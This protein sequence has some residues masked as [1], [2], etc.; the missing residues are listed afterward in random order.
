MSCRVVMQVR[1]STYTLAYYFKIGVLILNFTACGFLE[2]KTKGNEAMAATVQDTTAQNAPKDDYIV[3]PHV[4]HPQFKALSAAFETQ[5]HRFEI[6]R[7]AF[8]YNGTSFFIGDTEEKI[9][10]IFGEPNS[11]INTLKGE[12]YVF[13]YKKLKVEIWFNNNNNT[14]KS[15]GLLMSNYEGHENTP[16]KVVTFRKTPYHLD[17]TLNEFL[18]LSDLNHE[19]NLGHTLHSFYIKN[20]KKCS[21]I[22][23]KTSIGSTPSY[24]TI[25]GG[26]ITMKGDF[27]TKYSKPIRN[28]GMSLIKNN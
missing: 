18:E 13:E 10:E 21:S 9:I 25:G 12:S 11:K 24:N 22:P 15:I 5:E 26:H 27:D 8:K 4:A 14:V 19:T 3:T 17:M 16:Y 23:I 6:D 28:I 1:F 2:D 7:C 20:E